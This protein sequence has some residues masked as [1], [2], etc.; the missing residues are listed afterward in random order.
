VNTSAKRWTGFN[1]RDMELHHMDI[2][3]I[4]RHLEQSY[5]A[6][7]IMWLVRVCVIITQSKHGE[8]PLLRGGN[9][10]IVNGFMDWRNLSICFG[11]T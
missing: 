3:Y 2:R 10:T 4:V 8:G 11:S 1:K 7:H 6:C 5:D 9:L